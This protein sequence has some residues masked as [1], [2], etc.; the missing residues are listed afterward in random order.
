MYQLQSFLF[1]E[2]VPQDGYVFRN[3]SSP[4]MIAHAKQK[5]L[6]YSCRD[7]GH[8]SQMPFPPL[9]EGDAST[10]S[11]T[12][13]NP[14]IRISSSFNNVVATRPNILDPRRR[15]KVTLQHNRVIGDKTF[16]GGVAATEGF[17]MG[18][19]AWAFFE[20][21]VGE[22]AGLVRV[23]WSLA[24][25]NVDVGLDDMGWGY[26]GNS[27]SFHEGETNVYGE[28]FTNGDVIGCGFHLATGTMAFWKNGKYLGVAF[29][30]R[31]V[32][33]LTQIFPTIAVWDATATAKFVPPFRFAPTK[34]SVIAHETII[35]EQEEKAKKLREETPAGRA[36][37]ER[38]ICLDLLP[39]ELII[40]LIDY[41][42]M[43][44]AYNLAK[45]SKK[46]ARMV[47]PFSLVERRFINCFYTKMTPEETVLGVGVEF[48]KH[49]DG[50]L[51]SI[52]APTVDLLSV[53]A[54]GYGVRQGV[55]AE[56]FT[57]FLPVI[58]SPKHGR[59]SI[60]CVTPYFQAIMGKDSQMSLAQMAF[61][62]IPKLM[63]SVVV[64]FMK[65]IMK[66]QD[67]PKIDNT[68]SEKA[69][70]GYT[71]F[72]HMLL[73]YAK[74]FPK[75]QDN[76]KAAICKFMQNPRNRYKDTC[77]DLGEWLVFLSITDYTWSSVSSAFL[78]ECFVRNVRWALRECPTLRR[79]MGTQERLT[80][81]WKAVL[82]SMRLI[83][84]QVH[85]LSLVR[86]SSKTIQQTLTDYNFSSGVPNN[87]IKRKLCIAVK[88][89]MQVDSWDA[90]FKFIETRNP[91]VTALAETLKKSIAESLSR[92]Y[93]GHSKL[94]KEK[95]ASETGEARRGARVS[96]AARVARGAGAVRGAGVARGSARVVATGGGEWLI[97]ERRVVG[98]SRR[99]GRGQGGRG[100]GA[101]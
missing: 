43:A 99:G 10:N 11:L 49:T 92:G 41:L 4:Y 64:D 30:S 33:G 48:T 56:K 31:I 98:E 8:N 70:Q 58:L 72:H 62:V 13:V 39:S 71:M 23:G 35:A 90:F 73:Y 79:G 96:Q 16:W 32:G 89:I 84:F 54:F 59:K 69:L 55:W 7:C 24:G 52:S 57:H 17:T 74:E 27:R 63:N 78:E 12:F 83:M 76:A 75:I 19:T 46:F 47:F 65:P 61:K 80:Q 88:T 53:D 36:A 45:S 67:E 94:Q 82:T 68:V 101:R 66:S 9:A 18:H 81:T 51:K 5:I 14:T 93:H 22:G 37:S 26:E 34:E 3:N 15:F 28:R 25:A 95:T 60:A 87:Y 40:E 2:N 42:P 38:G 100:R 6:D 50:S 29:F 44:D 97:N 1:D 77:P 21:T 91:G 85:F 86:P 20:V